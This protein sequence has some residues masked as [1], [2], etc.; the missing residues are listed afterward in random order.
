MRQGSRQGANQE[1]L[2]FVLGAPAWAAGSLPRVACLEQRSPPHT[3]KPE[4]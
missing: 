1:G 3:C 2:P 4:G